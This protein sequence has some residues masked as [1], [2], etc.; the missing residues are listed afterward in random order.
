M[1]RGK[2]VNDAKV[3]Q[4]NEINYIRGNLDEQL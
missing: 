1:L 2:K 3:M 4:E